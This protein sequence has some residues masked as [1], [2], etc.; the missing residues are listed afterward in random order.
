MNSSQVG[1]EAL[2]FPV[3]SP[4]SRICSLFIVVTMVLVSLFTYFI[5]TIYIP[6]LSNSVHEIISILGNL[7]EIRY[8]CPLS[9]ISLSYLK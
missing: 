2:A 4:L 7:T 3:M 5:I 9:L 6:N 8:C 1:I